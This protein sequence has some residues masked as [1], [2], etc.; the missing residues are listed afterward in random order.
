MFF[1]FRMYA[2]KCYNILASSDV[3]NFSLNQIRRLKYVNKM[4]LISR[5]EL[6]DGIR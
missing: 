3:V 2:K 6:E 1:Y 4:E 5:I